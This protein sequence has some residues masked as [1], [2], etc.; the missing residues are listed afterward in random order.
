MLTEKR[1]ASIEE[2]VTNEEENAC[3][4]I[5]FCCFY[6]YVMI[7]RQHLQLWQEK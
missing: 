1:N 2:E 5:C 3:Q 7:V 4:D 6:G